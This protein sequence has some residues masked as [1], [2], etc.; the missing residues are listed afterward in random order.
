MLIESS[1]VIEGVINKK[2]DTISFSS[3]GKWYPNVNEYAN[4]LVS[5]SI[6]QNHI[7]EPFQT[8]ITIKLLKMVKNK[9]FIDI[10]SHIGYYTMIAAEMDFKVNAYECNKNTFKVLKN[11][12]KCYDKVNCNN[13]KITT[14]D[15]LN[16][17]KDTKIGLMKI[18]IE[19][20]EPHLIK[21]MLK[22]LDNMGIECV[23]VE[24]SP[25]YNSL[26]ELEVMINSFTSRGYSAYDIGN[27]LPRDINMKYD[28]LVDLKKFDT[29][30]LKNIHQTNLLFI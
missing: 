6:R 2:L 8:E 29:N 18:D 15:D 30:E 13:N 25:K 28:P 14:L 17:E 9:L 12:T 19:G 21:N 4:D 5:H 26:G 11:N 20:G 24:V 27:S 1:I 23:I 3:D 7:W 22:L 16:L 10:G